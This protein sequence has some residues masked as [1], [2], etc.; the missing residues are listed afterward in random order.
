VKITVVETEPAPYELAVER[1]CEK[2][3]E[4]CAEACS[5]PTCQEKCRFPISLIGSTADARVV[6]SVSEVAS[7]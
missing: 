5:S 7:L 1:Q 4:K 2:C 6:S 3:C